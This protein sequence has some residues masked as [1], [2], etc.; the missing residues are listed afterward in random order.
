[1]SARARP[2]NL[3]GE[4][5]GAYIHRGSGLHEEENLRAL[6]SRSSPRPRACHTIEMVFVDDGSSDGIAQILGKVAPHDPHVC[7]VHL[8]R[9]FGHHPASTA[10]VR[11]SSGD[12]V[13][14]TDGDLQ[15]PPDLVREWKKGP[16]VVFRAPQVAVRVRGRAGFSSAPVTACSLAFRRRRCPAT[17][18]CSARCRRR[19]PTE[20]A[21][22]PERNRH[23]QGLRWRAGHRCAKVW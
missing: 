1:L 8:S 12:A 21:R 11:F 7:V 6:Y 4:P 2:T 17:S 23:L 13:V 22:M 15:D 16:G 10:A 18:A 9:N 20:I 3:S 19:S 14:L 5:N